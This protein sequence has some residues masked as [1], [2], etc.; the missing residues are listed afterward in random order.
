[1]KSKI[2]ILFFGILNIG[3]GFSQTQG[4]NNYQKTWATYF[5]GT[6]IGLYFGA[7]DSADNLIVVGKLTPMV[8]NSEDAAYFNQFITSDNPQLQYHEGVDFQ[9][10]IAKF[11]PDGEL[12]QS[13]YLPFDPHSFNLDYE[14]RIYLV[15]STR[16][17]DLGTPGV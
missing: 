16:S 7:T 8:F 14:D 3:L 2:L 6:G 1:M 15:G 9:T 5:G 13:G 4:F 12:L 11:S 10:V 17:N